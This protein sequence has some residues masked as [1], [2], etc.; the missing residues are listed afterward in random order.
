MGLIAGIQ[1]NRAPAKR[2]LKDKLFSPAIAFSSEVETGS[3]EE[4][5]SNRESRRHYRLDVR[6]RTPHA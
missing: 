3:R 1:S 2:H 4:N 6:Q 5:S